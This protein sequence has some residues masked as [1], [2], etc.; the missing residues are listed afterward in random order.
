ME[1]GISLSA[2]TVEQSVEKAL[3]A[4][5]VGI[6][7]ITMGDTTY[8]ELYSRMGV[9]AHQTNSSA[10]GPG[11]TNPRTRH[12]YVTSN[13]MCTINELSNGRAFLGLSSGHSAVHRLG[14]RPATLSELE[15]FVSVFRSLC[16]GKTVEY[17]DEILQL[18]WV[19]RGR[20]THPIPVILAADGPKTM[21][22]GGKVADKV[23]IGAGIS[24]E[25]IEAADRNVSDGANEA[26]RDPDEIDRWLL[27]PFNIAGDYETAVDE[28]KPYLASAASHTFRFTFEGKAVPDRYREPIRQLLDEYRF[29]AHAQQGA[30]ETDPNS[31][32]V[33]RLN[34]TDYL[35]ERF[36][37]LGTAQ[38]CI[39]RLQ[40]VA[41]RDDI[42]SLHLV[43]Q[44]PYGTHTDRLEM[45][46]T[47]GE[48][49]IPAID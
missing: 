42:D 41:A 45:I 31:E 1:F 2:G 25:V 19:R 39:D 15:T 14:M 8:R 11:V 34:L 32:L 22:L 47:I 35:A 4:E 46:R 3:L 12:P 30:G 28:M 20:Q 17:D 29:D 13:A 10:L 43:A 27:V 36:C 23:L 7:S 40:T 48:D 49:I 26:S 5:S 37:A 6:D 33:D 44:S 21:R 38:D 16:E 9:V 24:P 18:D